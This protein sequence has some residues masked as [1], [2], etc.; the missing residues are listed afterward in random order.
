MTM[1]APDVV[2]EQTVDPDNP[3]KS[4]VVDCPEDK[5][6]TAAWITEARVFG[7]EVTALCGHVFVPERNPAKHP[8]CD[9]CITIANARLGLS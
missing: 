2:V 3:I 6:S 4:H 1:L 5:E 7:L 8:I 9:P